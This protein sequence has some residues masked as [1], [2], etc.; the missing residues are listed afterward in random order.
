MSL[1]CPDLHPFLVRGK[2]GLSFV[3]IVVLDG[4][5]IIFDTLTGWLESFQLDRPV[6]SMRWTQL[7]RQRSADLK[8]QIPAPGLTLSI[9]RL[10]PDWHQ[11][12]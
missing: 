4:F 11:W 8:V 6:R 9:A 3:L 7:L 2:V 10:A 5:A 1:F 12:M